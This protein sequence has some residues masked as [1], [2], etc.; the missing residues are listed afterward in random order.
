MYDCQN[1]RYTEFSFSQAQITAAHNLLGELTALPIP[2]QDPTPAFDAL[3]ALARRHGYQVER[4]NGSVKVVGVQLADALNFNAC[5]GAQ[6]VINCDLRRAQP[7][8]FSA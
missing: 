4:C 8:R 6:L 5:F 2:R 7:V 3:E 1:D